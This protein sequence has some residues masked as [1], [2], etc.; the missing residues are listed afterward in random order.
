MP[1]VV[2]AVLLKHCHLFGLHDVMVS[3]LSDLLSGKNCW[4]VYK[5]ALKASVSSG[6]RLSK[7]SFSG[8]NYEFATDSQASSGSC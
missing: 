8:N 4:K 3:S 2:V 5:I 6:T 7:V 1:V